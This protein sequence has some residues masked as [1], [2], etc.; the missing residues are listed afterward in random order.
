MRVAVLVPRR[1]DNGRRDRLW[2]WVRDRWSDVHPTFEIFE[3]EHDDGGP[4]NRSAAINRAAELAGPFD[5]AIVADSDSFAG[6]D[7]IDAA[8][9]RAVDTDR[10]TLAYDR[11]LYLTRSMSDQIMGGFVGAWEPGVE[12]SMS[13]TCS[14]LVVIP[15]RLWD[16]VGGFDPGFVGWGMEDVAASL[17]MQALRGGLERIPGPVWHLHHPS[18]SDSRDGPEFAANVARMKRYEACD[19]SRS[20]MLDLLVEL[21]RRENVGLERVV[22]ISEELGLY[23]DPSPAS[24]SDG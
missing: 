1:A 3:G 20:R 7:Q 22:A 6:P 15:R 16:E 2:S 14:S 24:T 13:G 17:A 10:M 8:V 4:F 21:G 11:F 18:S 23:D 19:Y 5:I 12:W 9:E